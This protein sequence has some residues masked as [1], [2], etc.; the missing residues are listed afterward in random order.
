MSDHITRDEFLAH[1]RP[2]QADVREIVV[3][4]REQA[5]QVHTLDKR[6]SILED[7]QPTRHAIQWGATSGT[8]AAAVVALMDYLFKAR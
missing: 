7:R 6:L 4:L 8:I 1:A 5:T 2:L 3:L